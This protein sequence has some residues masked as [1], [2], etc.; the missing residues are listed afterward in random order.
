MEGYADLDIGQIEK[1]YSNTLEIKGTIEAKLQA[2]LFSVAIGVTILTSSLA[3]LYGSAF[4]GF[5]MGLKL[6][7]L[8]L[9]TVAVLYMLLGGL[10][11]IMTIGKQVLIYTHSPSDISGSEKALKQIIATNTELNSLTNILRQNFMHVSLH[12]IVNAICV[13]FAFFL[14][15]GC[16]AVGSHQSSNTQSVDVRVYPLTSDVSNLANRVQSHILAQ[17]QRNSSTL[18]NIGAVQIEL[19]AV[20]NALSMLEL[21]YS[22]MTKSLDQLNKR[23]EAIEVSTSAKP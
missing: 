7:T 23:V 2:F 20:T 13:V 12:C 11:A 15:I 18:S 5:G 17:K 16:L 19:D 8:A 10:F 1:F 22:S 14:M 3:L 9:I 4:Q 6:T 21:D